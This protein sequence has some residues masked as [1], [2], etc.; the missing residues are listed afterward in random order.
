MTYTGG[1]RREH[2]GK[3]KEWLDSRD[4]TR[5]SQEQRDD[6]DM[7]ERPSILVPKVP[8]V[9]HAT[10][11]VPKRREQARSAEDGLASASVE[12]EKDHRQ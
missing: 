3:P 8:Q 5:R 6:E 9:S 7:A 11:G 2:L 12:A 4:R 10:W 1:R